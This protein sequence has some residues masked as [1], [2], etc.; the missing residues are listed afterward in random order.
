[1]AVR[2]KWDGF[3]RLAFKEGEAAGLRGKSGKPL[4]RFFPE[5]L[6]LLEELP[7]ERLR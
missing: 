5:I 2:P 1:V 6:A 4:S 3:R 7:F